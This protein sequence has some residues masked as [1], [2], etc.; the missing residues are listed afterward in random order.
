MFRY[1]E[2]L[3]NYAEAKAELGEFDAPEWNKSIKLLRERAGVNGAIPADYDPYLAEYYLNQTTDKWLLEIRRERTIELVHENLRYDDLMRWKLGPLLAITWKGIYFA[4]KNTP[5][6]LNNDGIMDVAVVDAEPPASSKVP[7]V[8]Y[9]VLGSSYKLSNGNSGN[10][11]FGFNQGRL[12]L[13]K[14]Y[15][16][17]VPNTAIQ[18]NPNLKPQNPGWE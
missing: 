1:A 6:D 18:V 15:L 11:E 3:L 10:L 7:G 8:V 12:W 4:Q 2:V 5:Y 14:K 9:V 16:R 13:D 17:P